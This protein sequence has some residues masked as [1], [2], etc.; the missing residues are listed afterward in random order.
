MNKQ[1][2]TFLTFS[3][4][5]MTHHNIEITA[6]QSF[7]NKQILEFG[8][9]DYNSYLNFKVEFANV[10][11][12]FAIDVAR[13]VNSGDTIERALAKVMYMG[14]RLPE[15]GRELCELCCEL[16]LDKYRVLDEMMR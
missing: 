9:A 4:E 10:F 7:T 12:S 16:I 11:A 6:L 5:I 13:N 1:L 8:P 14:K 3:G 15:G 2:H